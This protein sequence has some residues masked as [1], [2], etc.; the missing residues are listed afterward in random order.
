M[1]EYKKNN[2]STT[3][4]IHSHGFGHLILSMLG[5]IKSGLKEFH[6]FFLLFSP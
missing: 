3:M 1:S 6:I 2:Y 4:I 5:K